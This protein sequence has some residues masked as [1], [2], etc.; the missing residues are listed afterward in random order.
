MIHSLKNMALL[1]Y[2]MGKTSLALMLF[3]ICSVAALTTSKP[4]IS[5]WVY[6]G[7]IKPTGYFDPLELTTKLPSSAIKYVRESELQHGRVAMGAFLGLLGL[8]LV[9]DKLAIN[10]LYDLSWE[11]QIP[12]WMSVGAFEFARMGAGWK[13]CFVEP[14]AYFKLEDHYQP[15]NVFKMDVN[16]ITEERFNSELS[17]GRLAMLGTLG[18]IAQEYVTGQAPM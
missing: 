11:E 14:N 18:Y 10:F 16:N 5:N 15:G 8:D 9:Q 7:D 1:L 4:A 17:N 2:I 3:H 6:K 13:N 12:F